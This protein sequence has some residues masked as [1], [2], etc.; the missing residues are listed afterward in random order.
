M[1]KITA[2]PAQ[3]SDI[4]VSAAGSVLQT[5]QEAC[6]LHG[7]APSIFGRK[8]LGDP[9]LVHDI[10]LGRKLRPATLQRVS[11][12]ISSL[13]GDPLPERVKRPRNKRTAPY[14]GS[15]YPR[16]C[17]MMR[18]GSAALLAAIVH[19]G[20][21]NA[22]ARRPVLP[23][24]DPRDF[25]DIYAITGQGTCMEPLFAD[26]DL[27]VGDKRQDPEP[28]DTVIIMFRRDVAPRYGFPGW[29]K[30]LVELWSIDGE[31][32]LITLEQLN[33]PRRYVISADDIVSLHKCVGTAVST[34]EGTAAFRVPKG[35]ARP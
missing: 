1:A 20:G 13:G 30:R 11:E 16:Q 28:G 18:N 12:C 6:E 10:A 5:I 33:P 24:I 2:Q 34:G 4:D 19:A 22:H 21:N 3:G 23:Y 29:I 31:E 25:P 32:T 35:E 14:D 8:A 15:E 9:R 26:G 27:L 17:R 7:V